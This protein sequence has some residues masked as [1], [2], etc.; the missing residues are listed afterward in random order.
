MWRPPTNSHLPALR[1]RLQAE[2]IDFARFRANL[3]DQILSE[4]IREREVQGRIKVSDA[5]IDA[6]IAEQVARQGSQPELN[7]AQILVTVPE[8]ASDAVVAERR[9]RVDALLARLKAGEPFDKVAREASEDGNRERGG[10]IG[11]KPG[12]PSAGSVRGRRALDGSRCLHGAAGAQRG[13]LPSA[14]G[15]VAHRRPVA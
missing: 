6:L 7:I 14:Q 5:E 11:S 4:R 8:G 3:K 9:A 15:A 13:R 12:G 2:G 1:E 10:E